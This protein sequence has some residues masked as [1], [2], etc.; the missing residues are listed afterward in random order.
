MTYTRECVSG[1]SEE[2]KEEVKAMF[3][4]YINGTVDYETI[5]NHFQTKFKNTT[6]VDRIKD[7]LNVKEEPLPSPHVINDLGIRKKTQQWTQLE[8]CRLIA[9]LHR[10][11]M[12]NWTL[13]AHFVGNN[14]TRSQCSQRWQ[15][16]LDPRISRSHWTK[17]E[18]EKLVALV[19]KYG[20]KSWIGVAKEMGNR[21]DVQCRYR[22]LQMQRENM[23]EQPKPV[24]V[25]P[26]PIPVIPRDE[27]ITETL[28]LSG[29]SLAFEEPLPLDMMLH[30]G[31]ED[32]RA[33]ID[34][35]WP[36]FD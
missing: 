4:G 27:T 32:S 29:V 18:E 14:R 19:Q 9:G 35:D 25:A 11:G 26:I 34:T 31:F 24:I 20:D 12:D 30:I 16:G 8:D 23:N 13:V 17:E 7:V 33:L 3:T 15:R 21:S 6:P 28:N 22:Y 36:M 2:D 5:S 10:Y 1:I